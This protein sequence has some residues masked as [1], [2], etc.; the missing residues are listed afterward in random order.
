MPY[1]DDVGHT[2][3]AKLNKINALFKLFKC[4]CP[5]FLRF[6]YLCAAF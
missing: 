3:V 2:S 5:P 6:F 4:K 1:L